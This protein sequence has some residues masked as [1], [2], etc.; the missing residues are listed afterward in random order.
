MLRKTVCLLFLISKHV[1]VGGKKDNAVTQRRLQSSGSAEKD[2]RNGIQ[3]GGT[4]TGSNIFD[5]DICILVNSSNHNAD[6]GI[7]ENDKVSGRRI[8]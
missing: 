7:T 3:T 4:D 8:P 2:H 1:Q 6:N 5:H